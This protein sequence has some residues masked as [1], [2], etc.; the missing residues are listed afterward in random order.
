MRLYTV[1][2]VNG[3]ILAWEGTQG[4]AAKTKK[5]IKGKSWDQFD[6]PTGKT[7][8]LEFLNKHAVH[9]PSED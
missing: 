8:L 1:T 3:N 9:K 4:D 7:D 6:V 2:D 5:E